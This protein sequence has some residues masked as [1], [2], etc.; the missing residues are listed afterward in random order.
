MMIKKLI[1]ALTVVLMLSAALVGGQFAINP[2]V[3][4]AHCGYGAG[5][6][7]AAPGGVYTSH[8]GYSIAFYTVRDMGIRGWG[9][10][11]A[12]TAGSALASR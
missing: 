4:D 11:W 3:A 8:G 6:S 9:N 12:T 7:C 5:M 2:S 1:S 10:P